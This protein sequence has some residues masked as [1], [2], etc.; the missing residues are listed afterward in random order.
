MVVSKAEKTAATTV[1][2]MA[3]LKAGRKAACWA[4]SRA[5]YSAENLAGPRAASKA[6]WLAETMVVLKAGL[7]AA[8]KDQS[9]AVQLVENSADSRAAYSV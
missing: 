2:Q 7:M 4:D 6:E 3:D 8:R 9:W 1:E 5:A